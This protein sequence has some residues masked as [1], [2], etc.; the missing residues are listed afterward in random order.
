MAISYVL[1]SKGNL[2]NPEAQKKFY[3]Q[4]K[5]SDELTLLPSQSRFHVRCHCRTAK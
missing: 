1:T 4:A 2:A 3:A 5:S